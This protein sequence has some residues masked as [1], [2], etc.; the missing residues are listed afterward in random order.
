MAMKSVKLPSKV[1]PITTF[2][3]ELPDDLIPQPH[4]SPSGPGPASRRLVIVG[5]V[6]GA[7][8]SLEVLLDKVGFDKAKGDHLILVGDLVN[9]GPDSPGVIDLAIKLGASAVRGNHD[10]AVLVAASAIQATKLDSVSARAASR[11]PPTPSSSSVIDPNKRSEK[12]QED[13]KPDAEVEAPSTSTITA[14]TLSN[15][16]I[17]WLASLPLILRIKLGPRPQSSLGNIVVVHAGLVPGIPLEE[18]DPHA[19]MHMRSLDMSGDTVVPA[20]ADGNEGWVAAWDRSQDNLGAGETP[21]TV[22]FGHD[23]KRGV[24]LGKYTIGLDSACVYGKELSALL[25]ETTEEGIE[26]RI[27]QVPCADQAATPKK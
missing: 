13:D 16:Q 23:A 26:H 3:A 21:T 4:D 25:I 15:H 9:K 22:V 12:P 20:E 24:Q 6:H 2:I 14:A 1:S 10:N 5:D 11:N 19:I 8:R 17:D 18:Q 27:V 7:R